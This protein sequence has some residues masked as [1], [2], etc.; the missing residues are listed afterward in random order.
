MRAKRIWSI[1]LRERKTGS[2]NLLLGLAILCSA[3]TWE[4]AAQA[5]PD[6]PGGPALFERG[7]Y[8]TR[9]ADCTA[10]HT[11]RGGQ[12]FA[13]GPAITLPFGVLYAPNIT[14]DRNTGIGRYNDDEFVR[15]MQEGV[16]R[17]GRHLY[18]AFPYVAYTRMSRDDILAIKAYLFSLPPVVAA[19]RV[20]R[21][22]FP[23]NQRWGLIFWNA[24]FNPNR[25]FQPDPSRSAACNRGAYLVEGPGHCAQCHTPRNFAMAVDNGQA[26]A[27]AVAQ[28]WRAYN[29]TSDTQS[30]LGSWSDDQIASYLSRGHADQHGSAGGPMAEVVENSGR[31]MSPA[32]IRDI[33]V[34]LRSL[35]PIRNLSMVAEAPAR[36]GLESVDGRSGAGE[37]IF[38]SVC[39]TCHAW[40]GRGVQDPSATLIGNRTVNDPTG[41][42]LVNILLEGARVRNGTGA[43]VYMPPFGAAYT[44]DQIAAV[45][46]FVN[47]RFGDRSLAL[48]GTDVAAI[49]RSSAQTMPMAFIV[50]MAAVGSALLL[51][52]SVCFNLVRKRRSVSV[53]P[54]RRPA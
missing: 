8:L 26:F 30:G 38:A 20:S 33:V 48:T 49:R 41:T 2:R 24:L 40:N 23:F 10:C 52:A 28:G 39:A 19:P 53:E 46:N 22:S 4:P 34:F 17:D 12:A 42:N 9:V 44:D 13:G 6:A 45:A 15:A 21:L 27:G 31:Y 29:L 35:K 32:D 25:R 54:R 11:T 3:G 36:G 5:Q 51:V 7:E 47:G 37:R 43:I 16:A 14:P 50:G 18:P 1:R